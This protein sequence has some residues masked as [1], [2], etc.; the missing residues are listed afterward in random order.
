MNETMPTWDEATDTPETTAT[1][2]STLPSWDEATDSPQIEAPTAKTRTPGAL[3]MLK[4]VGSSIVQQGI[5]T[6]GLLVDQGIA[7]KELERA[8]RE[9]IY[10]SENQ[11][12]IDP[13]LLPESMTKGK[14]PEQLAALVDRVS[15]GAEREKVL[16]EHQRSSEMN[17][18]WLSEA[19]IVQKEWA[20]AVPETLNF[21]DKNFQQWLSEDPNGVLDFLHKGV[22]MAAQN[23]GNLAAGAVAGPVAA[24]LSMAASERD[25]ALSEMEEL[26]LPSEFALPYAAAHGYGAGAIENVQNTGRLIAGGLK[27]KAAKAAASV[28][29]PVL[30]KIG[31]EVGKRLFDAIF[32]QAE[33]GS[34]TLLGNYIKKK[35]VDDWNKLHPEKKINYQ[36]DYAKDLKASGMGA[37]QMDTVL[38]I[39]GIS[40]DSM[41]AV[42]KQTRLVDEKKATDIYKGREDVESV[43]PITD[44]IRVKLKSGHVRDVLFQTKDQM[45]STFKA[46]PEGFFQSVEANGEVGKQAVAYARKKAVESGADENAQK[47]LMVDELVN[48]GWAQIGSH[49]QRDATLHTDVGLPNSTIRLLRGEATKGTLAHE[50]F[51]GLLAE[52]RKGNILTES[53]KAQYGNILA[54]VMGNEED[55][56]HRLER[57]TD[58]GAISRLAESVLAR[59]NSKVRA[60]QS[61]SATEERLRQN[62]ITAQAQNKRSDFSIDTT[63]VPIE[64]GRIYGDETP[65]YGIS[66]VAAPGPRGQTFNMPEYAGPRGSEDTTGPVDEMREQFNNRPTP[67]ERSVTLSQH[68]PEVRRKLSEIMDADYKTL[69]GM[70]RAEGVKISGKAEKLRSALMTAVTEKSNAARKQAEQDAALEQSIK[71]HEEQLAQKTGEIS[72]TPGEKPGTVDIVLRTGERNEQDIPNEV[73][74]AGEGNSVPDVE[75]RG[76]ETP[77]QLRRVP[78]VQNA[79][80][81]TQAG[82]GAATQDEVNPTVKKS[83]KVQKPIRAT[84]IG[85]FYEVYGDDAKVVADAAGL[86]LTKRNGV[87]MVGFPYHSTDRTLKELSDSGLNVELSETAEN[88]VPVVKK[89]LTTESAKADSQPLEKPGEKVPTAGKQDQSVDSNK[90]IADQ[91]PDAGKMVEDKSAVP[92]KKSLKKQAAEQKKSLKAQESTEEIRK[93]R[94]SNKPADLP[95]VDA[96]SGSAK[97]AGPASKKKRSFPPTKDHGVTP[98]MSWIRDNARIAPKSKMRNPSGE[99]DGAP[100]M[101]EL[102]EFAKHVFGG[103]QAADQ[104][105]QALHDAGLI[106]DAYPD[107]MWEAIRQEVDAH[108][109]ASSR[110]KEMNAPGYWAQ[111]EADIK[112]VIQKAVESG[113]LLPVHSEVFVSDDDSVYRVADHWVD[114]ENLLNIEYFVTDGNETRRVKPSEISVANTTENV[115]LMDQFFAEL[116]E[117]DNEANS[118]GERVGEDTDSTQ[119][120]NAQEYVGEGDEVLGRAERSGEND[121]REDRTSAKEGIP[122]DSEKKSLKKKPTLEEWEKKNIKKKSSQA[123]MF[124]KGA[125]GNAFKLVQQQTSAQKG[126]FQ[127]SLDEKNKEQR[128]DEENGSLFDQPEQSTIAVIPYSASLD[129]RN[130]DAL[131]RGTGIRYLEVVRGQKQNTFVAKAWRKSPVEGSVVIDM[132]PGSDNNNVQPNP[133][134]LRKKSEKPLTGEQNDLVVENYE[135][136]ADMAAAAAKKFSSV[137]DAETVAH[138]GAVDGLVAAARAWKPSLGPF[139]NYARTAISNR[140]RTALSRATDAKDKENMVVDEIKARHDKGHNKKPKY[141]AKR[142]KDGPSITYPMMDKRR[143]FERGSVGQLS[144]QVSG[145][146][147]ASYRWPDM[148]RGRKVFDE[149]GLEVYE[150]TY[151]ERPIYESV[152]NGKTVQYSGTLE[153]AKMLL[154]DNGLDNRGRYDEA[155]QREREKPYYARAKAAGV[156]DSD[157][158]P[159]DP[160]IRYS[161]KNILNAYGMTLDEVDA[162]VNGGVTPKRSLKKQ[163]VMKDAGGLNRA[164][165]RLGHLGVSQINQI[166]TAGG[167]EVARKVTDYYADSHRWSAEYRDQVKPFVAQLDK[168]WKK[169]Y[170]FQR[171]QAKQHYKDLMQSL[172]SGER[173]RARE[174]MREAGMDDGSLNAVADVLESLDTKAKNAGIQF[175]SLA[176]YFPR[177][178]RDG[179]FDKYMR[180][181]ERKHSTLKDSFSR[182]IR[183][184]KIAARRELDDLEKAMAVESVLRKQEPLVGGMS[185][186]MK[187]RKI[188]KLSAEALEFYE[189]PQGALLKYIDVMTDRIARRELLSGISSQYKAKLEEAKGV[190]KGIAD[191]LGEDSLEVLAADLNLEGDTGI[192]MAIAQMRESGKIGYDQAVELEIQ[193]KRLFENGSA[194]KMVDGTRNLMYFL[195]LSQVPRAALRNIGDWANVLSEFGVVNTAIALAETLPQSI[196]GLRKLVSES[197]ATMTT[198]GF[199]KEMNDFFRT[200]EGWTRKAAD[201]GTKY[202]GMKWMDQL[203]KNAFL[204]AQMRRSSRQAKRIRSLAADGRDAF[205]SRQMLYD[206]V[207]QTIGDMTDEM[208]D[209]LVDKDFSGEEQMRFLSKRMMEF[210]PV[211]RGNSPFTSN[212]KSGFAHLFYSFR[213]Y[214]LMWMNTY[215][216]K[217]VGMMRRGW[218]NGDNAVFAKGLKNLFMY[219]T[220]YMILNTL[221]RMAINVFYDKD[222]PPEKI[223]KE[224]MMALMFANRYTAWQIR[225]GKV[226]ELSGSMLLGAAAPFTSA[227]ILDAKQYMEDPDFDFMRDGRSVSY[228]PFGGSVYSE[229]YGKR[230]A[231]RIKRAG[232]AERKEEREARK[233]LG[234][235]SLKRDLKRRDI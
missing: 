153:Q 170:L 198:L 176:D 229:R 47:S 235:K 15:N 18:D 59:L 184:A 187:Q 88:G 169:A 45:A 143:D 22:G 113:E 70:A 173:D 166:E 73:A 77:L 114:P 213:K 193:L 136:A 38:N 68:P 85:D 7:A 154:S 32:S 158:F 13:S 225:E 165:T 115:E 226:S 171:P 81:G 1:A 163:D 174:I 164:L 232:E 219:P 125:V 159:Y 62:L 48:R 230:H 75:Q 149:Q 141:S 60:N 138:D 63:S 150:G 162:F 210:F 64:A 83:L 104:V 180:Y 148:K 231:D 93:S 116:N 209:A 132:K 24:Y 110:E 19:R 192:G 124:G 214:T 89:S 56:A 117:V 190:T 99:Y 126:D 195:L 39:L 107:T 145:S 134:K 86:T 8:N 35:A 197:Q 52:A 16:S 215:A 49:E 97:P 151:K 201:I 133:K 129:I 96:V 186:N 101:T 90:M 27:K 54:G 66:E 189:S 152:R 142:F 84:R 57:R 122:G 5:N 146:H 111:V 203:P 40:V 177:F 218:E 25:S 17:K 37:A 100:R 12:T 211:T 224:E 112:D 155:L 194:G 30:K 91:V 51:H 212:S 79:G 98:V 157:I 123:E 233:S 105:A 208:M 167:I 199:D 76:P 3:D 205:I 53:E 234:K 137:R 172:L 227:A 103:T 28:A 58:Q 131:P 95:R 119:N 161:A 121:G 179:Q 65:S 191:V 106:Q 220:Y 4:Q 183:E 26:G 21:D 140:I 94:I 41:R 42:N 61:T 118:N 207:R 156:S 67:P 223:A 228:A 196:P 206:E 80:E 120:G 202:S 139:E 160:E 135:M 200:G 23:A 204:N 20:N 217:S 29:K 71:F 130:V 36:P 109:K 87:P 128:L 178:I 69:Q 11:S 34:Q 46:N 185:N 31:G 6:A 168:L 221:A 175:G 222:E 2:T 33:E 44:G 10:R 72:R 188:S 108:R 78:E 144:G 9:Q 181:L 216:K 127:K 182:A 50:D 102:G 147:R 43:T 55:A 14:S 74:N 92:A 82:R